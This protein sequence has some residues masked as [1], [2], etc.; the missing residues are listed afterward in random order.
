MTV[1]QNEDGSWS[2]VEDD[3]T[4]LRDGFPDN[5]AAWRWIERHLPPDP[6]WLRRRSSWKENVKHD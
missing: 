6:L 3:G 5:A 1:R 2:V 4:V